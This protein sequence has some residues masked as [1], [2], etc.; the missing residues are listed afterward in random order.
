MDGETQVSGRITFL[1]V[2]S[3]FLAITTGMG[4]L[5]VH[6]YQTYANAT[7]MAACA[8]FSWAFGSMVI[9]MMLVLLTSGKKTRGRIGARRGRVT[10][11]LGSRSPGSSGHVTGEGIEAEGEAGTRITS[12]I[13]SLFLIV[14]AI[15]LALLGLFLFGHHRLD[16]IG[17]GMFIAVV[18]YIA[19][20]SRLAWPRK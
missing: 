1:I 12:V 11:R 9:S 10:V 14:S 8:V 15:G 20:W 6:L 17:S 16:L 19:N 18:F 7:A 3:V 5:A 4:T 13:P 2:G